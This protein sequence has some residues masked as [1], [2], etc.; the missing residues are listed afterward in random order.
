M[1]MLSYTPMVMFPP[2]MKELA[3]YPESIIGYLLSARGVGNWLS[4]LIVVLPTRRWPRATLALGLTF[5][6]YP[7]LD[8][9]ARRHH[10]CHGCLLDERH[11]GLR[12]RSRLYADGDARF[13]DIAGPAAVEGSA[14]FNVLRHFGSVVFVSLSILVLV[15]G[16]QYSYTDLRDWVSPF[17]ELFGHSSVAGGWSLSTQEGIAA[18][19]G[20]VLRQAT[21]IGYINA[22]TLW[23]HGGAQHSVG[24]ALQPATTGSRLT[25][26]LQF[27][28]SPPDEQPGCRRRPVHQ[29]PCHAAWDIAENR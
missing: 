15:Y 29:L 4:F 16:T 28:L 7:A 27:H 19:N 6:R 25:R 21:M 1:G 22:F 20:E 23:D 26:P 8:G 13:L 11:A 18:L 9:A 14:L 10:E 17:N 3:G 24:F 2:M 12:I 5:K